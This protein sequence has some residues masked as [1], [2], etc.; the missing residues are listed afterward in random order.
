MKHHDPHGM[1]F[2]VH[3]ALLI[4]LRPPTVQVLFVILET[5]LFS[6][7]NQLIAIPCVDIQAIET[8]IC[9]PSEIN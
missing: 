7:F 8:N 5:D 1:A 2:K 9:L 4:A 3:E 6:C